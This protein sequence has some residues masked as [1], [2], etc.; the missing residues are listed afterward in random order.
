MILNALTVEEI[1]IPPNAVCVSHGYMQQ[2]GCGW[3]GIH[4]LRYHVFSIPM[5]TVLKDA[6]AF[7]H[8]RSFSYQKALSQKVKPS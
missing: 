2:A 7:V 5:Q 3:T 8:G 6:I 1:S 4:Q